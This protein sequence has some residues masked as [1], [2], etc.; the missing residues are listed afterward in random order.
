MLS[1]PAGLR[2][3]ACIGI[4]LT[5]FLYGLGC[6]SAISAV[7][8]APLNCSWSVR[9]STSVLEGC[10]IQ[11]DLNTIG[12]EF[13]KGITL[14]GREPIRWLPVQLRPTFDGQLLLLVN[15][16]LQLSSCMPL[17]GLAALECT[18]HASSTW[19]SPGLQ[20]SLQLAFDPRAGIH[21]C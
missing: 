14:N 16:T 12:S 6:Y 19:P 20:V 15:M 1:K 18:F 2:T 3:L 9:D 7:G 8:Q 10:T 17:W 13:N 11:L 5:L 21:S 4:R